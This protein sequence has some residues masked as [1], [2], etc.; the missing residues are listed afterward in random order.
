M[1]D[2]SA[3]TWALWT[4]DRSSL[5]TEASLRCPLWRVLIT[6]LSHDLCDWHHSWIGMQPWMRSVTNRNLF[7]RRWML[8]PLRYSRLYSIY[9]LQR[10]PWK[11]VWLEAA[12]YHT[13]VSSLVLSF[14]SVSFDKLPQ[15]SIM[16]LLCDS[17]TDR[18]SAMRLALWRR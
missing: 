16:F 3:A 9:L 1:D 18:G 10:F 7:L 4:W 6:A 13:V 5:C 14:S 8:P 2:F 17:C 15:I 12:L 11:G